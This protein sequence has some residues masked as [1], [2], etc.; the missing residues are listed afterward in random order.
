M[1]KV[2]R[3]GMLGL[4]V[5]QVADGRVLGAHAA[6]RR[7]SMASLTKLYV[8][9]AALAE[10]GPNHEFRTRMHAL[11]PIR[12]GSCPGL[13]VVGGGDPCLDEHF[14]DGDPDAVFRDWAARLASAGVE[15]IDGDLIIDGSM[16][17]GPIRPATYP[18][19]ARNIQRWYCAPA[20]AFAWND[21]CIEVRVVPAS[22]GQP[23]LVETR[24]DSPRITIDNNTRSL[25][26]G[27]SKGLVAWRHQHANT[28]VVNKHYSSTTSWFPFAIHE[29]PDLLA[30]DH[31]ATVLAQ[32]GIALSG[33]VR[34]GTVPADAPLLFTV[35]NP[36]TPALNILNQR[37]QNFYGEQILRVLGH[38][39]HGTG[40]L[41]TGIAA[42]T[43]VLTEH[44]LD[45]AGFT[46][47]DGSGLSYGNEAS[48]RSVVDLLAL[49]AAH[50][51]AVIY[52]DSLKQRQV[53]LPGGGTLT[54]KVK[55]GHLAIAHCL[56]GYI[57]DDHG[58]RYAFACIANRAGARSVAW[59]DRTIRGFVADVVAALRD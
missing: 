7:L 34:R 40:S 25:G 12:D 57:T 3:G 42:T 46:L 11:G 31:L 23:A 5:T 18:G 37:S 28:V 17:S 2:P 9:A 8:S 33:Q 43:A 35:R 1:A 51:H 38:A 52:H 58:R 10:L 15:R 49:M 6:D 53:P 44:G 50:P 39:R 55:T 13:V 54:I 14:T 22:P 27:G 48:A 29:D 19:D 16:F 36:L 41:E 24:P 47:L 20:S 30:G 26:S 59:G 32:A 4:C 45:A 21:N 56:A